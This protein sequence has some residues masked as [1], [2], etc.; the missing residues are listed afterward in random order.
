MYVNINFQAMARI[1]RDGQKKTVHI[2]RLLTTVSYMFSLVSR[3]L[4]IL[5]VF[6]P[7]MHSRVMHWFIKLAV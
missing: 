1:W 6:V 4:C 2:Y 7:S 5:I 3:V